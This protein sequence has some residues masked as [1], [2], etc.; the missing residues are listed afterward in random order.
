MNEGIERGEFQ[1]VRGRYTGYTRTRLAQFGRRLKRAIYP[2]H[3]PVTRIELAG[4][5]ERI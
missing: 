2:A 3:E 5:T 4:P 1:R